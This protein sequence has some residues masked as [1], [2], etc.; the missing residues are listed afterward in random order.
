MAVDPPAE[1]VPKAGTLLTIEADSG[2]AIE[3]V[4]VE[5]DTVTF[6]VMRV[7]GVTAVGGGV[8]PLC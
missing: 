2:Q 5:N 1:T 7:V 6:S 4:D 3:D 8:W